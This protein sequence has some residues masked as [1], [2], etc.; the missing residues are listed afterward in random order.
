MFKMLQPTKG[1]PVEPISG[2]ATI[3]CDAQNLEEAR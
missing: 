2:H 1:I 3:V